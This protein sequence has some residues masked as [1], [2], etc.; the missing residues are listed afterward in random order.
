MIGRAALALAVGLA[1]AGC[2]KDPPPRQ[3]PE[4]MTPAERERGVDLCKAYVTRLCACAA[5]KGTK[6][7]ADRCELHRGRPDT[8]ATALSAEVGSDVDPRDVLQAQDA[9]RKV[10][11]ACVRDLAALDQEGCP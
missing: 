9:A 3:G 8:I 2:K 10:M 11:A 7:L 4:P 1:L 6:E 5:A